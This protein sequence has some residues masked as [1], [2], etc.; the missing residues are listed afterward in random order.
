M[1]SG[2]ELLSLNYIHFRTNIIGI[3]CLKL[4]DEA[5]IIIIH[6]VLADMPLGLFRCFMSKSEVHAEFRTEPF[7]LATGVDCTNSVN[8]DQVQVLNHSKYHSLFLLSMRLGYMKQWIRR[9]IGNVF[10]W[11]EVACS[12]PITSSKNISGYIYIYIYI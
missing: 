1:V 10:E 4:W 11:Q 2:F 12:I 6:N 7:I 9:L 5:G 3:I 8:H